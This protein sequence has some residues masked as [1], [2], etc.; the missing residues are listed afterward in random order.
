MEA[1][2]YQSVWGAAA[3]GGKHPDD[4]EGGR[5]GGR[6]GSAAGRLSLRMARQAQTED[7]SRF[8]NGGR[9]AIDGTSRVIRGV[10]L[11]AIHRR[12]RS[13]GEGKKWERAEYGMAKLDAIGHQF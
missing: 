9:Q 13:A 7:D 10:I 4:T 5:E 11:M 2:A 3:S 6:E 1:G 12:L 8:M